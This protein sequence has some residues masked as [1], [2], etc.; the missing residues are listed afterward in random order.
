MRQIS[1]AAKI[2]APLLSTF[3]SEDPYRI[4]LKENA[5]LK[6]GGK[7]PPDHDEQD[8]TIFVDEMRTWIIATSDPPGKQTRARVYEII[9]CGVCNFHLTFFVYVSLDNFACRYF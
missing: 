4:C 7:P 8:D 5:V 9:I 3:R 1:A 2:F 6:H